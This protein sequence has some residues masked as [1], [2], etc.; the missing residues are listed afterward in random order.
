[1][2]REVP[3][4]EWQAKLDSLWRWLASQEKHEKRRGRRTRP[5][6]GFTSYDT[7]PLSY[8][9]KSIAEME[10]RLDKHRGSE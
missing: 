3:H 7:P 4:D 5:T 2:R 9:K 8:I 6:D 10:K 1:M